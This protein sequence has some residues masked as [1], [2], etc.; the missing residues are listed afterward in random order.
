MDNDE[1]S[2][3]NA[4][5]AGVGSKMM[6]RIVILTATMILTI[7]MTGCQNVIN[8]S[9]SDDLQSHKDQRER[10]YRRLVGFVKPGMLRR[11]LYALLPPKDTP[12]ATPPGIEHIIGMAIFSTHRERHLL[13]S[14][15]CLEVYYQIDNPKEYG[16]ELRKSKQKALQPS[17][18]PNSIDALLASPPTIIDG[19]EWSHGKKVPS[20]QNPNDVIVDVRLCSNMP[21]NEFPSSRPTLKPWV[22]KER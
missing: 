12:M 11:Q 21:T 3:T 17:N 19:V 2:M 6:F 9:K 4:Q 15:F 14:D 8:L 18:Q 22:L 5:N 16:I 20:R 13:D 7:G 10:A 1:T